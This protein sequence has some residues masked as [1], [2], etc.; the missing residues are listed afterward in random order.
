[1]KA[2]KTMNQVNIRLATETDIPSI[3]RL[4]QEWFDE[5]SVYGFEPES[6]EQLRLILGS[7]CLV[8]E[9]DEDIIGF[10]T[11]FIHTSDGLAVIPAGKRYIEVDNAYV[12]LQ[13]RR[14]GIGGHLVDQLLVAA[15]KQ[16]V[17]Y[18]LLYS[19]TKDIRSILKFYEQ[20]GFQSWSI[21]MFRS[22]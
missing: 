14:Q 4:Q 5:G 9:M 19:A 1:M 8:A 11:G 15:E 6:Q 20:H 2:M 12:S 21:Q 18:A 10:V 22:L 17:T 3:C 13:Y 16:G 7:F